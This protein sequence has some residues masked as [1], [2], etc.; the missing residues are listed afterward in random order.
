MM[1]QPRTPDRNGYCTGRVKIELHFFSPP[2]GGLGLLSFTRPPDPSL[3]RTLAG[4]LLLHSLADPSLLHSLADPSL[5]H[6]L[7]DPPPFLSLNCSLNLLSFTRSLDPPPDSLS[8][9]LCPLARLTLLLA[10]PSALSLDPPVFVARPT[11]VCGGQGSV[12]K[13]DSGGGRFGLIA[14]SSPLSSSQVKL[15]PPKFNRNRT[16]KYNSTALFGGGCWVSLT[17]RFH[18]HSAAGWAECTVAGPGRVRL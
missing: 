3:L 17:G 16:R 12:E 8:L 14:R 10:S 7:A 11:C 15:S 13:V 9:T 1:E 6:S 18:R 2:A 4:P 5:L